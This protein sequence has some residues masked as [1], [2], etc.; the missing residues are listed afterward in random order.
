MNLTEI[1][2]ALTYDTPEEIEYIKY[3]KKINPKIL[4]LGYL[5]KKTLIKKLE[6]CNIEYTILG[7]MKTEFSVFI[8]ISSKIPQR[9]PQIPFYFTPLEFYDYIGLNGKDR[10]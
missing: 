6:L 5:P 9:H 8:K 4:E 2:T 1:E 3:F 7:C 10:K